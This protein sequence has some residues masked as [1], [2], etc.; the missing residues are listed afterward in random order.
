MFYLDRFVYEVRFRL[1]EHLRV[2]LTK[3]FIKGIQFI[4]TSKD[5]TLAYELHNLAGLYQPRPKEGWMPPPD[6]E[7]WSENKGI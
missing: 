2:N 4:N 6:W 5:R 3:V 7:C 1:G